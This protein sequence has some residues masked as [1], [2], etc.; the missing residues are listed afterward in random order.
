MKK[1]YLFYKDLY[2][3]YISIIKKNNIFNVYLNT[4]IYRDLTNKKVNKK[5]FD[6]PILDEGSINFREI[7]YIIEN[8]SEKVDESILQAI[9]NELNIFGYNLSIS[10]KLTEE[11]LDLLDPKRFYN[12]SFDEITKEF[13]NNSDLYLDTAIEQYKSLTASDKI[14]N[15]QNILKK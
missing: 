8:L 1:I 2:K 11:K 10:K 14:E 12:M 7:G 3:Y 15:F 9:T 13:L 6:F 5:F 4:N